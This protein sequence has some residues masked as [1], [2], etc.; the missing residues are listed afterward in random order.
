[1]KIVNNIL[2]YTDCDGCGQKLMCCFK[3]V[4]TGNAIDILP[5][6]GPS[7]H[8]IPEE[9][10][11]PLEIAEAEALLLEAQSLLCHGVPYTPLEPIE[12]VEEPECIPISLELVGANTFCKSEIIALA[13]ATNPTI[14]DWVGWDIVVE[15]LGATTIDGITS[16]TC[17]V[18]SIGDHG[19]KNLDGAGASW[20]IP[21]N[22]SNPLGDQCFE[23][24]AGTIA[25]FN[26]TFI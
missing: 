9:C 22:P 14:T 13:Q 2:C 12:P 1:M 5:E 3:F 8:I 26:G 7:I 17:S 25:E 19:E 10:E 21:P 11:P 4:T 20:T 15:K 23:L 24:E 18:K 6:D 16:T